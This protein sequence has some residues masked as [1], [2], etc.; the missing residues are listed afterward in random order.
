MTFYNNKNTDDLLENQ[1]NLS[2]NMFYI[3]K[4]LEMLK[5]SSYFEFVTKKFNDNFQV[6]RNF[7]RKFFNF[8]LISKSL[9]E[10]LNLLF[11]ILITF[12]STKLIFE[13]KLT[14]GEMM[15]ITT[16]TNYLFSSL[17][18]FAS[19]LNAFPQFQKQKKLLDQI[20]MIQDEE[21]N[22]KGLKIENISDISFKD[23]SF[24]FDKKIFN[25]NL[26]S[27]NSFKVIGPNGSGKSS[28]LKCLAGI[29]VGE[30]E[31]KIN[32]INSE[33]YSLESI[34]NSVFYLKPNQ[35]FFGERVMDFITN[36]STEST[37]IFLENFKKF[38]L[39][40]LLN[41]AQINLNDQII[42]GGVN[43]SSGQK[44]IIS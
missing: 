17:L 39:D 8:G 6:Q 18:E 4:N 25:L 41:N 29:Y 9:S 40:V 44:Q 24:S 11:P 1:M 5:Q 16:S 33:Y 37:E 30:G 43:F 15:L 28:L 12:L 3:S 22:S 19:F 13:N 2:A 38:N 14:I 34:R 32:N 21:T 36:N 35:E 42:G 26:K 27:T 23:Y 31:F 20:F 10:L 7:E